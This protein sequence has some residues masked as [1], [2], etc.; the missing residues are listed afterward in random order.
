MILSEVVSVFTFR[1]IDIKIPFREMRL[2]VV[3][4]YLYEN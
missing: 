2:I 1:R 3:L 4:M